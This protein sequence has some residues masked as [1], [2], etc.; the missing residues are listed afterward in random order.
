MQGVGLVG[1]GYWGSNYLRVLR[2]FGDFPLVAVCDSNPKNLESAKARG[3]KK[4]YSSV[5]QLA[6]DREVGA[7]VVSTPARTHY[8][9]VRPLL[10]AGKHVLVEKPLATD[11]SEAL[12]LAELARKKN[13]VLMVGHIFLFNGAVKK[14]KE[15]VDSGAIGKINY[16]YATRTGLGPIRNDVNALWDLAC[17]DVYIL[18]HLIGARPVSVMARGGSFVR[19]D[20]EDI[21]FLTLEY[22]GNVLASVHV[23]WLDPVKIRKLTIVGTSKMVVFDDIQVTEPVRVFDKGV[24]VEPKGAEFGEVKALVRDGDIVSPKVVMREPLKAEVE[25]F[26]DCVRSGRKPVA[27]GMAGYETVK[28]LEAAQKAVDAGGAKVEIE[29]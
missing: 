12:E 16:A 21:V 7:V 26:Y 4:L 13:V 15:L 1:V 18:G 6:A 11:S 29:W 9:V 3:I 19:S 22:P 8:E 14:V 28:V 17:H 24:S 23:S 27:D 20:I 10:E 25:H 2:E 5:A